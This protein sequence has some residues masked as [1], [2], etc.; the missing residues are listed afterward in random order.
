MLS[1]RIVSTMLAVLA[2]SASL[3]AQEFKVLDRTVQVHGFGAQGFVYTSGNNW[4]TMNSND[5]SPGWTEMGL[6]MSTQI[7]D[8]LRIGAQVYDRNLGQLGQY[9]PT[10]DW[11]FADYKFKSWLGVRG[12]KVKTTLGLFNDTQ[13]L[14]FL[15]T[16]AL[17]PQGMYPLD[18]RDSDIAHT[19]GDIYG[20]VPLGA[21][22]G[23]LAYTGYVGHRN[24]GIY[25]ALALFLQTHDVETW[26]VNYGGLQFG[27]DLR[28]K[29]P[30]KGLLIGASRLEE[31]I[32]GNYYQA[33]IGPAWE[34]SAQW[35]WTNQ[36]YGEYAWHN[37][38]VDAEDKRYFRD[39]I[40]RNGTS[41]DKD[42]I[43]S[44]YIAGSY[45]LTK[46]ISA[47][48]YYSHYTITSS[49][50]GLTDTSQPNA[51]DFDKVVSGKVDIN[52]FWN[53]KVEGHFI[54]GY[55]FGPYPN[56]FYPQQNPTFA[57]TTKALVMKTSFNF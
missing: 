44:W 26:T 38:R 15:R 41:E 33:G 13:D 35:D 23:S 53:V 32:T 55:A 21:K 14:D 19:G 36:F 3:H 47:G 11:G 57:P 28:W 49:D 56:G 5:G 24:D 40:I 7:T 20:K 18:L 6:N 31:N 22:R 25:S 39:H 34:K 45:Q 17:L 1:K 9:H 30:I 10:F 27:G 51:H 37:L 2:V 16:F 4:L 12:G 54:D 42:D 8:K 50:N 29:T 48:T 52:R 43:R 46:R